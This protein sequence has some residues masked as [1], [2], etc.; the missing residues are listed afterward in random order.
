MAYSP[1]VR[2]RNFNKEQIKH[3]HN[4]YQPSFYNMKWEEVNTIIDASFPSYSGTHYQTYAQMGIEYKE[5]GNQNTF[6]IQEYLRNFNDQQLD[7][8]LVFW[9]STYF[10]PNSRVSNSGEAP[11]II[12]VELSR[13][14]L[15]NGN[16]YNFDTFFNLYFSSNSDIL[17]NALKNY[18][19]IIIFDDTSRDF[20]IDIADIDNLQELIEKIE[21][22]FPIPAGYQSPI[23]LFERYNEENYKKFFLKVYRKE[24]KEPNNKIVYG[25]PGT[26]KSHLIQEKLNQFFSCENYQRVTFYNGYTYGQFVGT[27]KPKTI[28]KNI[29]T[30]EV[31][32]SSITISKEHEPIITY[33][34]IAGPFIKLLV[35]ALSDM[36]SNFCLIIEE[37][38]R[39]KVD[40]VFGDIFQLL[41]RDIDGKSSYTINPSNELLGYLKNNLPKSVYLDIELN[42]LYIPSNF[43]IWATMNSADQGVFP[44]DTAFKRRWSF[45]YISLND[46]Q[47]EMDKLDV[48]IGNNTFLEYNEFR[49]KINK[50]LSDFYHIEEDKLLAPFFV[51]KTDFEAK[52]ISGIEKLVLKENVFIN[53]IVMYL[54]DDILRHARNEDIFLYKT[55]SEIVENY[56]TNKIIN[57]T[58]L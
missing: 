46:K 14:I 5:R 31:F 23:E 38:N 4:L 49:K 37:I 8:F 20:F 18:S 27:F 10:T 2:A 52:N 12:F 19:P 24:I 42:G 55:F 30:K 58:T 43:Y 35:K 22:E 39:T 33:E 6:R 54:K 47:A 26:G 34:F 17:L 45:E 13:L 32:H 50:K 28:Y 11:I 51:K 3:I 41:D 56:P 21:L 40:T 1:L 15:T 16:R 25:A 36:T 9:I 57:E 44:I 48:N 29:V 7:D 53:K